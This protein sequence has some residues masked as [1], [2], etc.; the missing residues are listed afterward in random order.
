MREEAFISHPRLRL[1]PAEVLLRIER[2]AVCF[3]L[4]VESAPNVKIH[5][6]GQLREY[7]GGATEL[8]VS[9]RTVRS[10]LDQLERGEPLLYRNVCDETGQSPPAPQRVRQHDNVRDLDGVDTML[11]AGD[12]VTFLPS[13][14]RRLNM[15]DR[16]VLAIGTKKGVFVAEATKRA[17]QLRAARS[18]RPRR[19]RL[20]D[21]RSTR[22]A[23]RA[24][25]RR[26]AIRSSA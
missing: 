17:A 13:R 6:F 22:A 8:S 20:L 7:C 4:V 3:I 1:G 19:P 14:F 18:V 9:A 23:R 16:V 25:T 24:S 15:A 11:A 2:V 10:L 12:V 26:A 5:V 21:A